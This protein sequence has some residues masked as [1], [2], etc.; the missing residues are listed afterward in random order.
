[1]RGIAAYSAA[2]LATAGLAAP[3]IGADECTDPECL[4]EQALTELASQ[5]VGGLLSGDGSLEFIRQMMEAQGVPQE[6][7]DETMAMYEQ[8]YGGGAGDAGSLA[9]MIEL[10]GA[11]ELPEDAFAGLDIDASAFPNL[12]DPDGVEFVKVVDAGQ[13]AFIKFGLDENVLESLG[14]ALPVAAAALAQAASDGD[15][16]QATLEAILKLLPDE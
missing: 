2:A 12:E 13:D 11:D 14:G 3:A 5:G 16:D 10:F 8:F 4:T 9:G 1:M 6:T 7:I 15:I